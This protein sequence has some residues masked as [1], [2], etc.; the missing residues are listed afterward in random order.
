[1]DTF[2]SKSL[3]V[4]CHN[5]VPK[6]S[7]EYILKASEIHSCDDLFI[8]NL[9]LFLCKYCTFQVIDFISVLSK[10]TFILFFFSIHNKSKLN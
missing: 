9:W 8:S 5:A 1:M 4:F 6:E 7:V 2:E 10:R 3:S